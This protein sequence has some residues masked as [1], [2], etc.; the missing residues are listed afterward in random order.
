MHFFAGGA[1]GP[2]EG[3]ERGSGPGRGRMRGLPLDGGAP[4]VP[5]VGVLAPFAALNGARPAC[6]VR[7]SG[8]PP[9]ALGSGERGG[10]S[11]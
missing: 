1:E 4:F 8:S 3:L 5:G 2:W 7:A 10:D 11:V 6:V 9:P